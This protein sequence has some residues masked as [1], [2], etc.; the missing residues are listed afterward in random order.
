[1]NLERRQFVFNTLTISAGLLLIPLGTSSNESWEIDAKK[2]QDALQKNTSIDLAKTL[3]RSVS[4]GGIFTV[5]PNGSPLPSGLSLSK[6]GILSVQ[7]DKNIQVSG[8]V[9]AY[10]EPKRKLNG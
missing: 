2:I 9:F 10:E 8:V 3:P 1:M 4:K 6:E 5:D 7:F